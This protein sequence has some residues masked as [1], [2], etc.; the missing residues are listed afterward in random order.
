M[1]SNKG[2]TL[3]ELLAV[4][5]ILAIIAL[6]A[7]PIILDVIDTAKKG[8][9]ESSALGYVDAVEKQVMLAQV[10]TSAVKIV[11]GTYTVESL[12]NAGVEV[13]GEAPLS[14]G[15]VVIASNGSVESAWLQF[16][17]DNTVEY[18]VLYRGNTGKAV[19]QSGS[20]YDDNVENNTDTAPT[21]A[22]V[23]CTTTACTP[24]SS[25]E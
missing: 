8:A 14:T 24:V 11:A 2:F 4:I 9:K 3:I 20:T 7:T 19:A 25:G 10:D 21:A 23:T 22:T 15:Y 6:I 18:S 5:V 17:K 16:G 13:K 1:K 12:E